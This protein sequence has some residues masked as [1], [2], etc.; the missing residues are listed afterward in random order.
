MNK[1]V[2]LF[3]CFAV[4]FCLGACI[5]Q[6][7]NIYDFLWIPDQE[8]QVDYKLEH[9]RTVDNQ[10]VT[11]TSKIT[12]KQGQNFN[13]VLAKIQT[14]DIEQLFSFQVNENGELINLKAELTDLVNKSSL[15][16]IGFLGV[17]LPIILS[18]LKIYSNRLLYKNSGVCGDC[19]GPIILDFENMVDEIYEC[20]NSS[21]PL[22]ENKTGVQYRIS[23]QR[24]TDAIIL[25]FND[26]SVKYLNKDGLSTESVY[27]SYEYGSSEKLSSTNKLVEVSTTPAQLP[28]EQC[29]SSVNLKTK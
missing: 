4:F 23:Y 17:A 15:S 5:P 22:N 8:S 13:E 6:K 29:F 25:F 21:A 2:K 20:V 10:I 19:R 3:H 9:Q 24:S 18:I 14:K 16:F 27:L 12:L 11:E 7:P 1:F 26:F 28:Y